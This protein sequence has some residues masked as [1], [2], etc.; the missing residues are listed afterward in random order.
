MF[1]NKVFPASWMPPICID[2][3]GPW[4]DE[5]DGRGEEYTQAL[6]FQTFHRTTETDFSMFPPLEN[7]PTGLEP[8][9]PPLALH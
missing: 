9:I 2:R 7:A 4:K 8:A 3:W 5:V 6:A 1:R